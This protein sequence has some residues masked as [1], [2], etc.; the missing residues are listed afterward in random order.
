MNTSPSNLFLSTTKMKQPLR[1]TIAGYIV[2]LLLTVWC[3]APAS[4]QSLLSMEDY[5]NRLSEHMVTDI[6]QDERGFL[7]FSTWNGMH[8]FDGYT[9]KNYKTYP[10]EECVMVSNRLL[11]IRINRSGKI[12]CL[13]YDR[14]AYLFDPETERFS[15]L[16]MQEPVGLIG[17]II[18]AADSTS[19]LIAEDRILIIDER[20]LDLKRGIGVTEIPFGDSKL[21]SGRRIV[22]VV[23]PE[24]SSSWIVTDQSLISV[25]SCI[26][27]P[28]EVGPIVKAAT[29]SGNLYLITANDRIGTFI[30]ARKAFV[31]ESLPIDTR[32]IHHLK[33]I[34][35][36][37]LAIC[38]DRGLLLYAPHRHHFTHLDPKQSGC[39]SSLVTDVY[40]DSHHNLWIYTDR[41]GVV[42]HDPA[43]GEMQWLKTATEDIPSASVST[44]ILCFED[45]QG[46]MWVVPRGGGLGWFDRTQKCLRTYQ[47]DPQRPETKFTPTLSLHFIDRQGNLWYSGTS[48]LFRLSFSAVNITHQN[49]DKHFEARAMMS[50]LKGRLWVATKLGLIRIYNPDKTLR[51]YL[52]QDGRI[53]TTPTRFPGNIYCFLEDRNG[54]I[55]M[56]TRLHG[57]VR[58]EPIGEDR[59]RIT[60]YR[61][62]PS[63][64]YSLSDNS[65][66]D[67]FEDSHGRIWACTYGGGIN[68]ILSAEDQRLCFLHHGN[69]LKN[70]SLE[71]CF[72]TRKIIER[73]GVLLVGTTH[74]LV[75]FD[76]DFDDPKEI[77]FYLNCLQ[78]NDSSCLL[79][80][81]IHSIF[82]DSRGEC[83]VLSFTG[84]ISR[85]LSE[86]LLSEQI[87]FR[88]YTIKDG[89][90]S[91]LA[92]S[93]IE[94]RDGKLWIVYENAI[95]R[96]NP[97]LET[98]E[99]F[100]D[101]SLSYTEAY[102]TFHAGELVVG[103][104]NG[105][106]YIPTGS[107]HKSDFVPPIA[108]SALALQST[109]EVLPIDHLD[110]IKL[111]PDERDIQ[112]HFAALDFEDSRSLRY[113]YCMAGLDE[114]WHRVEGQNSVTY[115]NLPHGEYRFEIRS[116][117][118]DGVW[119][120]NLRTLHI[121][122][123][124]TFWETPLAFVLLFLAVL[125]LIFGIIQVRLH[126][127]QLRS[128][129]DIEQHM[130]DIKLRFFT[131][132]SH[133]LR[134]PLTL[135]ASPVEEVL[136]QESLTDQGRRHLQIV[137]QNTQR[138]LRLV[139]QILDFRK[140]ENGKMKVLAEQ[141]ELFPFVE[142]IAE[143]FNHIAQRQRNDFSCRLPNADSTGW[144][145]RDKVEKICFNLLS[146]AFKYTPEGRSVLFE[147]RIENQTLIIIVSDEGIGM[148]SKAQAKLFRR[149]E[150]ILGSTNF[151]SSGIG[152]S[153]VKELIDLMGGRIE[154]ES[155]PGVGSCFTV[156]LPISRSHYETLA[157]AEVLVRDT[158]PTTPL[159]SSHEPETA[160]TTT[161]DRPK[162]LIVEDN[163][164]LSNLLRD[165]LS[166]E[167]RIIV[168]TNGVEGLRHAGSE[169]PDLILTDIMMPEMDGLEMVRRIKEDRALCHLPIVALSAKSSI[170]DRIEGLEQGI[171][172]YITKPFVA[173]Y[174]K[175][176]IRRLLERY[177]QL[178]ERFLESLTED[179]PMVHL[180]ESSEEHEPHIVT[181]DERLIRQLVELIERHMDHSE[182]T[183]EDF[184]RELNM[185]HSTF[186]NKVKSLLGITP[187]E[188]I[189]EIR[190]KRGHQLLQ[191]GT[192]DV[193][194]VS[195]MVGF[196]DPRYFSKCFKKR[197]GISPSQ[198][199]ES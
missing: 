79:S 18:C 140:I 33:I 31:W 55:W 43:T 30:P 185:A 187:V 122:V 57:L 89:L 152:L 81:D 197:F 44:T 29:G 142:R 2:F 161:S 102:P 125:A 101:P 183:V 169:H 171:D 129:I 83:Y 137:S 37:E 34:D 41:T 158:T 131:D 68:C 42:R 165:I 138:M 62:D 135:I 163:E 69:E 196:S 117:N 103:T 174:L 159:G 177:R 25:E 14:N 147:V 167:Y 40:T 59:F 124:P 154:V 170:D 74:G 26:T 7:Y 132:V 100:S 156:M 94:D 70:W 112:I 22:D 144:F 153:L 172:D 116:T 87:R 54:T 106:A 194:T 67:L 181:S 56:G 50:D 109:G 189:R 82:T 73:Q 53:H 9:F 76:V 107:L 118:S 52:G 36:E 121:R 95:D 146:N 141:G 35:R 180:P 47:T 199:K 12:W 88:N 176:R 160:H 186:Y 150:N 182:M 10:G 151:P 115:T 58:M 136:Q 145:D 133:E 72:N 139:N 166:S 4:A 123:L 105:V 155:T 86:E 92:H 93:M 188:F 32:A 97:E 198:V 90:S 78:P 17:N 19:Y 65:I 99:N 178:R 11:M 48:G 191:S 1:F 111:K 98:F 24:G 126:I 96:F 127:F 134:T 162:L 64:P 193:S 75:T 13:D 179:K 128:R 71:H 63:D 6:Q 173:S 168:A 38:T 192:Y 3:I 46:T 143:N 114:E 15:E 21:G 184:A 16:K 195:Y 148:D 80:N 108:F 23:C 39:G 85:I 120:E 157:N 60:R 77:R 104:P 45:R 190:L 20:R 51:G 28:E 113:A 130:T 91:E 49:L 149:F 175:V 119:V 27:L 164:D 110:R 5:S 61:Y 8:R 66:Y 84:G